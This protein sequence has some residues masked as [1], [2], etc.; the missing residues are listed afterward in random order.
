M[1]PTKMLIIMVDETDMWEDVPL[2]EAIIRRLV[3]HDIAGATAL[4][5]IMGYGIHGKIHRRG[6][7]GV[8]DDR[9]VAVLSV[10]TEDKLR[11]ALPDIRPMVREGVMFLTD[12]E[13]VP[14][15]GN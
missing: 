3:R 1:S 12:V 4:A 9:P 15:S 2:Y 8:S 10:D 14:I 6:L 5:G 11:A 13:V 7:F